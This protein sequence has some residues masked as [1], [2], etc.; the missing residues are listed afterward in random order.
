MIEVLE[1]YYAFIFIFVGVLGSIVMIDFY[2]EIHGSIIKTVFMYQYAVYELTKDKLNEFGILILETITTL[3][4]WF[5]NVII[6]IIIC[7]YHILRLICK[8]FYLIFK[9]R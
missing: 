4:V 6:F 8:L 5:L 1:M 2:D 3:S 9:K 7:L